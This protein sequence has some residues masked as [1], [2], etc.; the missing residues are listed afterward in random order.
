MKIG[1]MTKEERAL[2]QKAEKLRDE[3]ESL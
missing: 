2:R 1:E 3:R